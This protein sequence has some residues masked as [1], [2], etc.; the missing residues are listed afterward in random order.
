MKR[1]IHSISFVGSLVGLAFLLCAGVGYLSH[2]SAKVFESFLV[3][4]GVCGG[5]SLGAWFASRK[6]P[7]LSKRDAIIVIVSTWVLCGFV[8][9]LPYL[10]LGTC[11]DV[12]SALFESFS[13]LTTTGASVLS[14]LENLPHAVLFWRSLTHFIGGIGILIM[15]IAV[16]PFVGA[17][18]VQLYK[19]E[20]TGLMAEKL[21]SRITETARIIVGIYLL[22]NVLCT[23]ALRIAGLS[24]FDS[25]CHAFGAIATGGFSTRSESVAAFHNPSVEWI[26]VV[27][28]FLSGV[29][30]IVHYR[31]LKGDLLGYFRNSEF[32]FYAA[33]SIVVI[34]LSSA[35]I[36]Q[37]FD[38]DIPSTIRD[39]TF[40]TISLLSTTGYTTVDY[41]VWPDTIK[42]LLLLLM[43]T[44]ACAGSTSGAI[45]NVRIIVFWKSCIRQLRTL[46]HPSL[47]EPIRLDGAIIT[48]ERAY[49]AGSYIVFYVF[50]LILATLLLSIFTSDIQ[51]SFSAVIAC[52]GGVG[53]GM[54]GAGP[55]E[56]YALIPMA[57]KIVLMLCMLLG[58]LEIYMCLVI[59]LPSF[60]GL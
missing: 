15:F 5:I 13:G 49:K 28:M 7:E 10:L 29:S 51:T 58:R 26:I 40:Q 38:V 12:V 3:L 44:G 8:G 55:T 17:G 1:L 56:T 2:D 43:I 20:S 41:D 23:V 34:I 48:D 19:T 50:T 59:F 25:V 53:P 52:L 9:A 31:A 16:L 45:K 37:Q 6:N 33:L 36:L 4:G 22:L 42:I 27:F 30:F 47:I 57:G 24:W 46:M 35:I 32:L 39:T 54:F 14:D 18:G 21:T 60:W 11:H